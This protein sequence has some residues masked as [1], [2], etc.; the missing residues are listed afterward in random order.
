[1]KIAVMAAGGVGGYFGGRLAQAGFDVG[2]IARGAHLAAMCDAGLR[3]NS[4]LGDAHIQPCQATDDP[5]DIGPVDYV[6]FATKLW[7]TD[8]AGQACRPLIG[9]ETAVISLQNGVEA[10]D[11]LQE[12][13]GVR[14]PDDDGDETLRALDDPRIINNL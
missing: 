3:I 1:M 4:P 12:P 11:L 8:S 5:A 14:S 10:G 7:D 9:P 2:F 6:L 13:V